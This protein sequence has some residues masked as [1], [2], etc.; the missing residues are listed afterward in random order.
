MSLACGLCKVKMSRPLQRL[1]FWFH[2][3]KQETAPRVHTERSPVLPY[4]CGSNFSTI[5]WMLSLLDFIR[6]L[7]PPSHGN[8]HSYFQ[9]PSMVT[10][11]SFQVS[12]S[13][14]KHRLGWEC[15]S[16]SWPNG[17]QFLLLVLNYHVHPPDGKTASLLHGWTGKCRHKKTTQ[18]Y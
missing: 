6:L 18:P 1:S 17:W 15:V 14:I 8:P 13:R 2:S 5:W 12:K 10:V 11:S 4:Y 3:S 16:S 9:R 7:S